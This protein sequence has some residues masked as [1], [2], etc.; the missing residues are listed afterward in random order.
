MGQR[1]DDGAPRWS[2]WC[3]ATTS[4]SLHVEAE[5][6]GVAVDHLVV[7]ALDAE[8]AHVAGLGPRTDGDQLVPAD[9][10]GPDEAPLEVG[11]DDPGA[12]G[13]LPPGLERPRPGLLLA[14]GEER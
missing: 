14:G 8:L 10:L 6:H 7:L 2:S 3:S 4:A 11:V 1:C 5:L 12:A 9:D 13:R